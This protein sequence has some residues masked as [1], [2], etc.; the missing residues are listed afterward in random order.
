MNICAVCKKVFDKPKRISSIQFMK[1]QYCSNACKGVALYGPDDPVDKAKWILAQAN[2]TS[3]GCLEYKGALNSQGYG[4]V[5]AKGSKQYLASRFIYEHL[6]AKIPAAMC[7]L[8][9]CDNPA[10]INPKHLFLGTHAE[11][12]HDMAMKHRSRGGNY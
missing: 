12:M 5:S 8:H 1:Q 2:E 10:C 9:K 4:R 3:K 6:V 11:N 7:V